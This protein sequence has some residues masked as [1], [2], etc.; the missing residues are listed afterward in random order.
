[1]VTIDIDPEKI[2]ERQKKRARE[3]RKRRRL[4]HIDESEMVEPAKETFEELFL[5]DSQTVT[6]YHEPSVQIQERKRNESPAAVHENPDLIAEFQTDRSTTLFVIELKKVLGKKSIG[7]MMFYYWAVSEG[8]D[9]KANEKTRELS[10]DEF[11]FST[12]GYLKPTQQYY[13]EF[14][15]WLRDSL[16]LEQGAIVPFQVDSSELDLYE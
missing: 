14:F 11:V 9:I 5:D 16:K 4:S 2:R 6:W 7:Q 10:G 12:I 13:G 15:D 1:M 8:M 3:R